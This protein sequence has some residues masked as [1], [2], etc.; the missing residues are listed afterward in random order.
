M[1]KILYEPKKDLKNWLRIKEEYPESFTIT[2]Y[3]PFDKDIILKKE[4]F[5][6][7][8]SSISKTKTKHFNIQAKVIKKAWQNREDKIINKIT[9][10]LNT[11]FTK[12]DFKAN[13][14]TSYLMPYDSKDRWFMIS[15]HKDLEDQIVCLI[16]ELFHLYQLKKN[17]S[18]S[19]IEREK[20]VE[21]FLNNYL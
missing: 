6:K 18:M 19:K 1:T 12:I 2:R 4:N 17:P 10:Y 3:Y 5:R 8:L 11:P 16:H 21:D 20:E 7:I 9:D 14:T 15:T 13:L